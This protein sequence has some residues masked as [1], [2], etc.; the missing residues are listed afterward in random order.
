VVAGEVLHWPK[1]SA[2][3]FED[4]LSLNRAFAA[5]KTDRDR[6]SR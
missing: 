4:A 1:V 3:G 6:G 2:A 5:T